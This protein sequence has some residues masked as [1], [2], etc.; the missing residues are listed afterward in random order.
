MKL[1]WLIP[2]DRSGGVSSVVVS[3]CKQAAMAG[4]QVTMLMLLN[5]SWLSSDDFQVVS[6]GLNGCAREASQTLI[7]WLAENP[8]DVLFFNACREFDSIIPYVP[9]NTKCVYVIHDTSAPYWSPAIKEQ[10]NLEAIVAVSETVAVKLHDRLKQPHKLSIIHNGCAFPQQAESGFERPD[11]LIFLGGDNPAKGAF[12]VLK[13]WRELINQQF[14]G[15][16]HW[17]GNVSPEFKDQV[18]SLPH[19]DRIRLY[20][21]VHRDKIFS[22]AAKSKVLLVLTRAESFGMAAIEAMSM[23]CVP[24]AWDIETGTKVIVTAN[25]TGLFAPLGKIKALAIQVL[26]ACN[27]YQRFCKAVIDRARIDFNEEVMWNDYESL[28]ANLASLDPIIRSKVGQPVEDF[29]PPVHRFQLFPSR[30]RA[31]IRFVIGRSPNLGYWLRDM[32]GW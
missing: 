11:D 28:L 23:G 15:N 6:L 31:A 4:H 19:A 21:H 10:D 16:L 25:E 17:F 26:Y 32:R 5:P 30:L 29:Q 7:Q 13:L 1:C 18:L 9:A 22:T 2:S 3:C 8:Q 27:H 20:G 24:L 14:T 12:D